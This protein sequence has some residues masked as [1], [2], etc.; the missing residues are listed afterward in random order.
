M[1]L[2][3]SIFFIILI[4]ISSFTIKGSQYEISAEYITI[5]QGLSD[6]NVNVILKDQMGFI[7]FGTNDGLNR[8]D[9]F[10]VKQFKP[11]QD[12]IN[13]LAMHQ[14]PDGHIWIG[15][16]D[17]L[18][19][20]DPKIEKFVLHL[21]QGPNETISLLSSRITGVVGNLNDGIYISS[22]NGLGILKFK[23]GRINPEEI[24]LEWKLKED[25]KEGSLPHNQLMCITS[26][27]NGTYWLGT[28]GNLIIQYDSGNNSFYPYKID[29]HKHST[30][31]FY[32]SAIYNK[33][34]KL[35]IAS[36]GGGIIAFDKSTH[37]TRSITYKPNDASSLNHPDVYAV[38]YDNHG[39]MWAGTWHGLSHNT[40]TFTAP[41][42]HHYNWEHPLFYEKLENRIIS[43]LYD[44]SGVLWL[45]T[46]GGGAVK[47]NLEDRFFK[48]I[49]LNSRYEVKGFSMDASKHLYLATYHG[50][51]IK[52][53]ESIKSGAPYNL[54]SYT[55]S[56][57]GNRYI[58]SDIILSTT[59]DERGNVWFGTI[60]SSLIKYNPV[61][62]KTTVIQVKPKQI[63]DWKG[64]IRALHIDSRGRFWLGTT[65]GLIYYDRNANT[66][67]LTKGSPQRKYSLF[68]NSIRAILEDSKGSLWVGTNR[69]LNKLIYHQVDSFRFNQFNDLYTSPGVLDQKEVWALHEMP[70]GKLWIGY[71]GG[72]GY[73]DELKGSIHFLNKRN[74]L[75]H[76]F[77]TCLA[78]NGNND[79]WIGTNSGISKLDTRTLTFSNY[80]IANNNRAS[81]RDHKGYLYFGNHKGF[82]YF[83]PD[84]IIL[85]SYLSPVVITGIRL[86]NKNVEVNENIKGKVILTQAAPYTSA[87]EL[88]YPHNSFTIEYNGLSYLLQ[89]N[90][91]FMYQL[92]NYDNEWVTVDGSQRSVTYNNI[93]A[94][95]YV[96]K[97]KSANKDG[98]W[99]P[100]VT[101]LVI[102]IYPPWFK[103]WWAKILYV[104]I[105]FALIGSIFR[106]RIKQIY[107]KQTQENLRKDLEY[108]LAISKIEKEKQQEVN[109]MKSRFFM[110]ISHELRTPLTLI[111]API[112]ELMDIND[113]PEKIKNR[114]T[115]VNKNA[116]QLYRL[117]SQLLDLRKSETGQMHLQANQKDIVKFTR[118]IMVSF[119]HYAQTRKIDL[120]FESEPTSLLLWFDMP[121]LETILTN[122]LSNAIKFTPA[123]G[124]IQ[125]TVSKDINQNRC[126]VSVKDS[127]TGIPVKEQEH[128]FERFYQGSTSSSSS[129]FGSGIGLALVK[130]LVELHKGEITVHSAKG[131]GATFKVSLPLGK[132]HLSKDDFAPEQVSEH[133]TD[134]SIITSLDMQADQKEKKQHPAKDQQILIVEDNIE[135]RHYIRSIFKEDYKVIEANNGQEGFKMAEKHNPSLII[136]DIMMPVMDGIELCTAIKKD[137]ETCHIPVILLTAKITDQEQLSGLETGA[138]DYITKPF[139]PTILKLKVDNLLATRHR[140]RSYY[141]NKVTLT[142]TNLELEPK[143]EKFIRE[144]IEL[145]EKNLL[146]PLFNAKMLA[147]N[148]NMSQ[149]TL[150]RRIKTFTGDNIAEFIRSIRLKRA[151]QIV[152][153][154]Q[155]N[156]AEVADMVGFSDASYFRKCF[157]KQFGV[158]PSK[159]KKK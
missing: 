107:K 56:E 145:V 50:G 120:R 70:D 78:D 86:R 80:F 3:K 96:F 77:V 84:S 24:T 14:S 157:T 49:H 55:P 67:Y 68:N 76:N 140:L 54:I 30:S 59:T 111:M 94:G 41:A 85:D 47:I 131:K 100:D 113:L 27:N 33:G 13:I 138:D 48:R 37:T 124:T 5:Q 136:S 116:I 34:D 92:E 19:V 2:K 31:H 158:T 123:K 75:C 148:L 93:P 137:E 64:R 134:S 106:I 74:G 82:L 109:D 156:I 110:N 91:Q 122:L 153:S 99:N 81:F 133:K 4:L 57:K 58:P 63:K 53:R 7:W 62:E 38:Q 98:V 108:Q 73:F 95:E 6:N 103:T 45:G 1:H 118:S 25:L 143:D 97:V 90:N 15:T 132:S 150:Y 147:E 9:G 40:N 83:H 128:I 61:T 20:F 69:G 126:I 121:K 65:N 152:S 139:N 79:L 114:L 71:R 51:F 60:E 18:Y 112:Q 105:L 8:F 144:A 151:A 39:E 17:G 159:Y 44:S 43:M 102:T 115:R 46:H 119:E 129:L 117:I 23:Y 125:L 141:S 101:S 52:T 29:T 135:I 26:D 130:D 142:P 104:V 36:I 22:A 149:P 155:Y 146:N 35:I 12:I 88:N 66:F 42:F 127:G 32:L 87:I 11:T 72:L 89:H 28:N 10:T 21:K 154:G 16:T